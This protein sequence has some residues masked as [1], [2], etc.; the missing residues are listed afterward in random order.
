MKQCLGNA[1]TDRAGLTGNASAG[2]GADDIE[3]AFRAGDGERLV[4]DELQRFKSEV[5][6]DVE[7]IDGNRAGSGI[8]ADAGNGFFS[9]ACIN[10]SRFCSV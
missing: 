10:D 2:S 4:D 5:V 6:V 3:F 7:F 8:N 1:V 9:S